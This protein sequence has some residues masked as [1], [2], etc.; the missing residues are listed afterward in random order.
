M[1]KKGNLYRTETGDRFV[2]IGEALCNRSLGVFHR[3]ISFG[4][5]GEKAKRFNITR[6][7]GDEFERTYP[8]IGKN[9]ARKT[10]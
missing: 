9:Y 6:A 10:R 2:L 1:I 5:N 8:L 7:R 3:A 4:P